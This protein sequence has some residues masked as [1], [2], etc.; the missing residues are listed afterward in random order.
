MFRN[1]VDNSAYYLLGQALAESHLNKVGFA[2]THPLM[3]GVQLDTGEPSTAPP[4]APVARKWPAPPH[5]TS[6]TTVNPKV[7]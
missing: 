6:G 7:A 5:A 3:K 2:N 4:K 1:P